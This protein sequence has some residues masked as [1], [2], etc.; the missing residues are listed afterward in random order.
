MPYN[1]AFGAS[2][3]TSGTA[4]TTHVVQPEQPLTAQVN[5]WVNHSAAQ[6][7]GLNPP[8]QHLP[9]PTGQFPLNPGAAPPVDHPIGVPDPTAV[10]PVPAAPGAAPGEI[11]AAPPAAASS[12]HQNW[13][14]RLNGWATSHPERY[15]QIYPMLQN[16]MQ[17]HGRQVP[18]GLTLPSLPVQAVTPTA[19]PVN[20][21]AA[22]YGR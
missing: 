13:Q 14:E 2:G 9:I 18:Q 20:P 17:M 15:A 3:A 8:V 21:F 10:P 12:G 4:Q 1:P 16:M 6:I 19:A 22:G 5:N 11:P 7:P